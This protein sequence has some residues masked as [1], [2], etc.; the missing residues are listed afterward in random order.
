MTD[1][2]ILCFGDSNTHGTRALA[3]LDSQGR[4]PRAERWPQVM[5][6]ELRDGWEVIAE[7][8]PGRTTVFD[9]P[10]EGSHKNGLT[11]LPALLE[12]HRPLD[13]VIV[14]LG[15]NDTKTRFSAPAFD[16][17]KGLERIAAT[18]RLS[19]SGPDRGAPGVLLAAPVPVVETGVLAP[20]FAGA[21]EKSRAL[22]PLLRDVAGRLGTGFVDLGGVAEVDPVDG[23]H[24]TAEGQAAIGRAMAG[25]VQAM[26]S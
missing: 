22:A 4:F 24:L 14:M 19:G 15:T 20:M 1:R 9:D 6:A 8:H 23:V 10:V 5:A 7:G 21:A 16:I 18:I 11:V 13:L 2:T 3:T 25:A 26:F 12:T 17:A